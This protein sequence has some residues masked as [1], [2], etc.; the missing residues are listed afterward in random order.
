MFDAISDQN[1]QNY[2]SFQK[3][4]IPNLDPNPKLDP[5]IPKTSKTQK[6]DLSLD[7]GLFFDF[8]PILGITFNQCFI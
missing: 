6:I 1:Y 3:Q 5:K 8:D 2:H 7:F 4:A